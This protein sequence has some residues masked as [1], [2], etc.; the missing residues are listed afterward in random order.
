MKLPNGGRAQIDIRRKLVGYCL[1]K[2][3]PTGK[4]KARVFDSV[5]GIAADNANILADALRL[6][7]RDLDA[8]M[9][10]RSDEATKFEIELPVIGPRGSAVVRSGWVIERGNAVPRLTTCYVTLS[11]KG[12][13]R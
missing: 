11:K 3:H 10:S 8:R 13:R 5:L 12:S 7:A 2:S 1:N 6:A 4:H 9:K